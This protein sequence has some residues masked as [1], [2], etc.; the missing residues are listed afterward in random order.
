MATPPPQHGAGPY[1]PYTPQQG[2][3]YGHYGSYPVPPQPGPYG[4]PA[5]AAAL[6]GCRLCGAEP[7]VQATVRGHQGMLVLMRFLRQEGPF[8]RDCGFATYRRMSAATLWQGWWGPLS[9]FITPFTLLMNLG[10]RARFLK[11]AP[12]AGAILPTLDPGKALWR[13]PPALVFLVATV[14]IAFT[15]PTLLLL[16]LTMSGDEKPP[17]LIT[18]QCVHNEGDWQ[19]QKLLVTD[20]GSPLAQYRATRPADAPGGTCAARD[21][22]AELQYSEDGNQLTCLT[23]LR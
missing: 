6:Y 17:A 3:P 11:L 7:A 19:D 16:G 9:V 15:P 4:H 12:P 5:V 18:G 20:C 13:R 14:L 22:L 8:C 10:A 21:F 1:H 23:P 2:G